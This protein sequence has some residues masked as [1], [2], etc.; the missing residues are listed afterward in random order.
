MRP[1]AR[2]DYA[3]IRQQVASLLRQR[4]D[5]VRARRHK[6]ARA[7]DGLRAWRKALAEAGGGRPKRTRNT[8]LTIGQQALTTARNSIAASVEANGRGVGKLRFSADGRAPVFTATDGREWVWSDRGSNDH[9][10]QITL[11]RDYLHEAA[12]RTVV[13]ERAAQGGLVRS[14]FAS[15]KATVLAGLAPV[16]HEGFMIEIPTCVAASGALKCGT[17][18]VDLLLHAGQGRNARF[19]VCELK[20]PGAGAAADPYPALRQAIQYASAMDIEVNGIDGLLEPADVELYREFYAAYSASSRRSSNAR[21]RRC[22]NWSVS[23][24]PELE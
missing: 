20:R 9:R 22:D 14:F 15:E 17:G 4:L 19:V 3:T 18:N 24:P 6:V 2:D 7:V 21:T 10:A 16:I 12:T 1:R 13:P 23:A 8:V 11:L 5:H